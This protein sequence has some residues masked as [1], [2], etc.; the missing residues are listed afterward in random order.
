MISPR[1]TPLRLS[2]AVLVASVLIVAAPLSAHAATNPT[3]TSVLASAKAALKHVTSVHVSV[4]TT[5]GKTKSSVTADIGKT[6]GRESYVSGDESFTITV[7]PTY[8]YLSGSKNGL[9]KLM[10]LT[11][12]EQAKV[13]TQAIAMKKGTTLLAK[14]DKATK[15]FQLSWATA[16]T[17]SAPATTT[18]MTISA[19][20]PSL[21][22]KELVTSSEG[23]SKT[24]FSRWGANVQV[25]VPSAT[26]NYSKVF[27]VKK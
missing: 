3:T 9:V 20:K 12:S 19:G 26:I 24:T 5:A 14:R 17:S 21:P 25:K 11:A 4:K 7:T 22:L 23:E 13:G 10:D 2:A 6:D 18:V 16:A 8:A 15:G 1:R 27:P